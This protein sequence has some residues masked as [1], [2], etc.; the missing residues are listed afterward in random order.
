MPLFIILVPLKQTGIKDLL[1]G[2]YFFKKLS[3]NLTTQN[4]EQLG[5]DALLAQLVVF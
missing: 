4:V 3:L 5:G 2:T 1:A